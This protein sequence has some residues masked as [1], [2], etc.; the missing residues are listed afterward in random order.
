MKATIVFVIAIT[1]PLACFAQKKEQWADM[2]RD[3][4][5]LQDQVKALQKTQDQLTVL[6]QQT[7]DASNKANI[8]IAVLQS[9]I[10]E[11]L[12]EQMKNVAAPV[13]S[14]S[15]KMDTMSDSFTAMKEQVND[16]TGRVG[17]LDQKLTDISNAVRTISAPPP[18]PT[19][20]ATGP[21]GGMPA[22]SSGPPPGA[23]AES[24]Y[25]SARRD[26]DGGNLD[27]A[28]NEFQQYLQ[29]FPNTDT[30]PNAQFYVGEIYLRKGD[31]DNAIKAFDTVLE[32]YPDNPR[33][34]PDAHLMKGRALTQA[35]KRTAAAKEF[36]DLI[37]QFPRSDAAATAKT[38]LK[39]L[40][41][42][43]PGAPAR[44]SKRR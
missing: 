31:T 37:K 25:Q 8:A 22:A 10:N 4:A 6:L 12:G 23:S 1:L 39:Q 3:I 14:L 40:G 15:S 42:P 26:M 16:L 11:R 17:K 33:T 35:G 21:N 44:T 13:A 29:W 28:M 5:M 19:P 30:A 9:S 32:R 7:L 20:A 34:T 2:Q 41:Y 38:L 36:Q 43:V 24:T 27:L 18:V